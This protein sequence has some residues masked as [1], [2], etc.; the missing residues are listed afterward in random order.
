MPVISPNPD[1]SAVFF[2]ASAE[3]ITEITDNQKSKFPPL[4][5]TT[6]PAYIN[7]YC[8]IQFLCHE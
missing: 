4:F 2:L 3:K 6:L 1:F 7:L 8:C 5:K